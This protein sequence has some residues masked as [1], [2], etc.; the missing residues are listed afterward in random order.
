MSIIRI[1][2]RRIN[3]HKKKYTVYV[4]E[5]FMYMLLPANKVGYNVVQSTSEDNFVVIPDRLYKTT[6]GADGRPQYLAPHRLPDL[7]ISGT[8]FV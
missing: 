6:F 3:G 1:F 7:D 5:V 8:T 4:D 2:P